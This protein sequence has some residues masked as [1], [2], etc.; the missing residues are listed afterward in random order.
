VQCDA[1]SEDN[2]GLCPDVQT[3]YDTDGDGLLGMADNCPFHYN[4]DQKDG[5]GDGEG[6]LC[7]TNLEGPGDNTVEYGGGTGRPDAGPVVK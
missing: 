7:D 2:F 6:D 4:Q 5:D 1:P 3:D